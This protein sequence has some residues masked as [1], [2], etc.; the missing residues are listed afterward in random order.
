MKYIYNRN[1]YNKYEIINEL[2]DSDDINP[3][4]GE[5]LIG[6]TLHRLLGFIRSK[7]KETK[8]NSYSK[9]LDRLLASIV[10]DKVMD[11]SGVD[12]NVADNAEVVDEENKETVDD[13]K[14]IVLT[15]ILLGAGKLYLDGKEKEAEKKLEEVPEEI[16]A[17]MP[18]S[19]QEMVTM[20]RQNGNDES[21]EENVESEEGVEVYDE[22]GNEINKEEVKEEE[23]PTTVAKD[24]WYYYTIS[25][26]AMVKDPEGGKKIP[27]P[28]RGKTVIFK[29]EKFKNYILNNIG[30]PRKAYPNVP[31]A[32][33]IDNLDIPKANEILFNLYNGKD[34]MNMEDVVNSFKSLK[35]Y[36]DCPVFKRNLDLLL[37]KLEKSDE[38][39]DQM[40]NFLKSIKS[41]E[42]VKMVGDGSEHAKNDI[43]SKIKEFDKKVIHM[44]TICRRCG[45]DKNKK[46]KKVQDRIR[47]NIARMKVDLGDNKLE[48]IQTTIKE[49]EMAFEMVYKFCSNCGTS[50]KGVDVKE[51]LR[52]LESISSIFSKK[53]EEKEEEPSNTGYL[54]Q[55]QFNKVRADI[56]EASKNWKVTKEK[57]KQINDKAEE[58]VKV[59]E[60][61]GR[62]SKEI[63]SILTKAKN[64]LLHSKPYDEIRKNQ[65]RW[66]DKLDGSSRAVNRAGYQ[67]WV[68]KVT[69]IITYYK[70][71]LPRKV[72]T[73]IT[74]SLDK[75]NISNDYVALTQEFLGLN[76][77]GEKPGEYINRYEDDSYTTDYEVGDT[78]TY[79][80]AK[81]DKKGNLIMVTG[82]VMRID[83]E[84]VHIQTDLTKDEVK[85]P[86]KIRKT[87]VVEVSSHD[88]DPNVVPS[89]SKEESPSKGS[90]AKASPAKAS[91][92]K[93]SPAKE[94]SKEETE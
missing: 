48:T 63:M 44:A 32:I 37:T 10:L 57:L 4:F 49:T 12:Q 40:I 31:K 25:D 28:N 70:D 54:T 62:D 61:N 68:K 88:D 51:Q 3:E 33:L 38:P 82:K 69:E 39:N 59:E 76:K 7:A 77:R 71:Q 19:S 58:K 64:A 55:K 24:G 36:G 72:I 2:V 83:K 73:V 21:E 45:A 85:K 81:K 14:K 74:D 35:G 46:I 75:T 94:S 11:E 92:A 90:P 65:K 30:M 89:I 42:E 80:R 9:Q 84:F 60:V 26:R 41:N 15:P 66:Y 1:Q 87:Q 13:V 18:K 5:T 29:R 93:A 6:G 52:I 22:E 17:L 86:N 34:K 78:V 53:K 23:E 47:A 27:S 67:S 16:L 79:K 8:M 56:E 20:I 50:G 91:P 43:K